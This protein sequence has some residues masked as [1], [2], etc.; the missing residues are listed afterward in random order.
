MI[1]LRHHIRN[2]HKGGGGGQRR[3]KMGEG[4]EGSDAGRGGGRERLN[5]SRNN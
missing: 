1:L 5:S 3:V 2:T 4:A